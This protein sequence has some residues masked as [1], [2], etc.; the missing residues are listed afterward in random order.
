MLSEAIKSM[1]LPVRTYRDYRQVYITLPKYGCVGRLGV[2]LRLIVAVAIFCYIVVQHIILEGGYA[3]PLEG[4]QSYIFPKLRG[5]FLTNFTRDQLDDIPET[6]WDLINNTFWDAKDNIFKTRP[7]MDNSFIP[8]N[9]IIT[10]NQTRGNC[11][12][13]PNNIT[14]CK[15]DNEGK[16]PTT[17]RF[18][19][20]SAEAYLNQSAGTN[21][22]QTGLCKPFN[23]PAT[24]AS[25]NAT[26]K[27]EYTCEY[28]GW[29]PPPRPQDQRP[30]VAIFGQTKDFLLQIQHKVVFPS[31]GLEMTNNQTKAKCLF[32]SSN[33]EAK[34]KYCRNFIVGDLVNITGSNFDELA[35]HGAV[36]GI[37][38]IWECFFIL[39]PFGL[40]LTWT[41]N[42]PCLP[43]YK[44]DLVDPEVPGKGMGQYPGWY[45]TDDYYRKRGEDYERT[46]YHLFGLE[47]EYKET[48]KVSYLDPIRII[49]LLM[50]GTGT[51]ATF[52]VIF[53]LIWANAC[54]IQN[55]DRTKYERMT[56]EECDVMQVPRRRCVLF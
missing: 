27:E 25:V 20:F 31:Y 45:I 24:Q 9:V 18:E 21:G 35:G 40:N 55:F 4:G 10:P 5:F 46:L 44:I 8:T 28:Y 33:P 7:N 39:K 14:R 41:P 23:R 22:L 17:C 52:E 13:W 2:A 29:C 48:Y 37:E 11:P 54:N 56:W 12:D 16:D 1:C 3:T 32:S 38:I 49:V 15:P 53:W 19:K 43:T 50:A 36:I 6:H 47:L 42:N 34:N 30:K 51:W 26:K